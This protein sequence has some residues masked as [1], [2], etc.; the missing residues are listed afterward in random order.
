MDSDPMDVQEEDIPDTDIELGL[1]KQDLV[2]ISTIDLNELFKSLGIGKDRAIHIK[3]ERR[4]LKNR[5]F[6]AIPRAKRET[7]EDANRK[8]IDQMLININIQR[9]EKLKEEHGHLCQ[10]LL[11][12]TEELQLVERMEDREK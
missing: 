5:A 9:T 4:T 10:S 7:E 11:Q 1:S 3:Q 8:E 2:Q 12:L 6:A